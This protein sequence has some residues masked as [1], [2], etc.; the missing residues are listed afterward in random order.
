M[1]PGINPDQMQPSS[2]SLNTTECSLDSANL[3]LRPNLYLLREGN[4]FWSSPA[5]TPNDMRT[6]FGRLR[7]NVLSLPSASSLR[8]AVSSDRDPI[9]LSI[10]A[11]TTRQITN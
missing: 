1:P 11:Y 7:L 4:L 2:A 8:T 10:S 9:P 3:S 5:K 6:N